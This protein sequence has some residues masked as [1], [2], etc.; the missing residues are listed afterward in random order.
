[1]TALH[2]K[3]SDLFG[4]GAKRSAEEREEQV[5]GKAMKCSPCFSSVR[6][7]HRLFN[8]KMI[9]LMFLIKSPRVALKGILCCCVRN[10]IYPD[11]SSPIH[12][13][14][15]GSKAS[16]VGGPRNWDQRPSAPVSRVTE[17]DRLALLQAA[18]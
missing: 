4:G 7:G 6:G 8:H 14:V 1:M 15:G 11:C 5:G 13:W 17:R 9:I 10:P 16:W 2:L 18:D 3:E 12:C